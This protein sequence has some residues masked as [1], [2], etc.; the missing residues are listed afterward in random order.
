MNKIY[1]SVLF[2]ALFAGDIFSADLRNYLPNSLEASGWKLLETKI[3]R[4]QPQL[5]DYMDGGAE[6]YFAFNFR[7]LAMRNFEDSAGVNLIIELYQFKT[8]YDAYG[9]F[10]MLPADQE[11]AIGDGSGYS[12]GMLRFW[13][14]PYYCKIVVAGLI[15]NDEAGYRILAIKTAKSIET[16]IIE[17]GSLPEIVSLMPAKD[18]AKEGLHYFH[19]Y[20]AQKNLYYIAPSNVLMLSRDTETAMAVYY[21]IK[22]E[23][24]TLFLIKFPTEKNA[25]EAYNEISKIQ[26]DDDRNMSHK[27]IKEYI[28]V[29]FEDHHRDLLDIKMNELEGNLN[30]K[31]K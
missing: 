19:E 16:K 15:E 17:T 8:A 20:I 28:L 9:M 22:A 31:I 12:L 30:R 24:V 4:T 23:K 10:T 27:R 13:K 14:G 21:N 26:L 25:N 7:G 2:L 18:R 6:L 3:V 1:L 29:G 5:F 11:L